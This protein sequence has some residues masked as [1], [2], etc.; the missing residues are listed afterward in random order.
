[1]ARIISLAILV[2]ISFLAY[3]QRKQ[4]DPLS[5]VIIKPREVKY[6]ASQQKYID[7][8]SAEIKYE[9]NNPITSITYP[10]GS[11][12]RIIARSSVRPKLNVDYFSYSTIITQ[13]YL[14][15]VCWGLDT[16]C[17]L[18][19]KEL[20]K[21]E[22]DLSLQQIAEKEKKQYVLDFTRIEILKKEDGFHAKIAVK[23]Y[24]STTKRY[25][26]DSVFVGS[27][28]EELNINVEGLPLECKTSMDCAYFNGIS[29]MID[30]VICSLNCG[31]I[32]ESIALEERRKEVLI[33]NYLSKEFDKNILR[34]IIPSSDSTIN[35]DIA[36]QALF[37][38]DS[39]K[40]ISFF[41]RKRDR[42]CSPKAYASWHARFDR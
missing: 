31:W 23:F 32:A 11:K 16:T 7:K 2:L 19:I 4:F 38:S 9:I 15:Y 36:F 12:K 8:R 1:M 5:V 34:K 20:R 6:D 18:I 3:S 10:A 29:K 26:I 37:N 17:S 13:S 14:G 27:E 40:F 30:E 21:D 25:L 42:L 22:K 39:T 35:V 41:F 24:N 33:K 28:N